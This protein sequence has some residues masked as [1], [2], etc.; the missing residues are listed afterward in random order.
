MAVLV[1][2]YGT[3]GR[4]WTLYG[5]ARINRHGAHA[6]AAILEDSA[7]EAAGGG[8]S[9]SSSTLVIARFK[10]SRSESATVRISAYPRKACGDTDPFIAV[11]RS[12]SRWLS[13]AL[14]LQLL[15]IAET[16]VRAADVHAPDVIGLRPLAAI[17][18]ARRANLYGIAVEGEAIDRSQKPGTI[19]LQSPAPGALAQS[20]AELAVL[21]AAAPAPDCTPARLTLSYSGDDAGDF[22]TLIFRDTSQQACE[23]SGPVA[24]S[25]VNRLGRRVTVTRIDATAQPLVLTPR[26]RPV[27]PS[28][29]ARPGELTATIALEAAGANDQSSGGRCRTSTI[30]PYAW[31]AEL[32]TRAT[33]TVRNLGRENLQTNT[34]NGVYT[35]SGTFTAATAAIAP[36]QFIAKP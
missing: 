16:S 24:I 19:V 32:P 15:S 35:C 5:A 33:L 25:G 22:G 27:P 30:V 29:E 28:S 3:I 9:T 26:A 1:C 7:E 11:S 4:G 8:C 36:T 20:S 17:A 31:Q 13:S 23:L 12:G 10:Y 18:A 21:L 6:L 14:T 34:K 2:A